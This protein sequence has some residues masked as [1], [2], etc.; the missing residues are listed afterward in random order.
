MSITLML[1]LKIIANCLIGL[2]VVSLAGA[3]ISA[4]VSNYSDRHAIK[5]AWILFSIG[6]ASAIISIGLHTLLGFYK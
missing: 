6:G 5:R 2:T 4:P 3:L 1:I